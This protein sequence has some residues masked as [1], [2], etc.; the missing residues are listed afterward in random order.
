MRGWRTWLLVPALILTGC[1]TTGPVKEKPMSSESIKSISEEA[2]AVQES[3]Y[4]A[5]PYLELVNKYL[6]E[7]GKV[8]Y[9]AWKDS[10]QDMAALDEQVG[11]DQYLQH[12]GVAGGS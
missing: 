5:A 9:Q 2:E 8:D 11:L 7:D 1:Q 6:A 10:T 3:A 4:S 12:A